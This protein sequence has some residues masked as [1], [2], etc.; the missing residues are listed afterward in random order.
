M[1]NGINV[2]PVSDGETAV[3]K[4]ITTEEF[5]SVINQETNML[6]VGGLEKDKDSIWV[7]K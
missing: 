1:E 4:F 6:V 7:R 5:E 3:I 2:G